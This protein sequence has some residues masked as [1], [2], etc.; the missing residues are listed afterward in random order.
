[1]SR[2]LAALAKACRG[3]NKPPGSYCYLVGETPMV[4]PDR[5]GIKTVTA[6]ARVRFPADATTALWATKKEA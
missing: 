3:H 1:M 2:Y 5:L 6:S 4:C